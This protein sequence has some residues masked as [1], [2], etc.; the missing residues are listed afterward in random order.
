[1][2]EAKIYN[3]S[4][5]TKAESRNSETSKPVGNV[6]TKPHN[7]TAEHKDNGYDHITDW[8]LALF[9]FLLVI[10]TRRLYQATSGLFSETAGL[11]EAANQQRADMLRSIKAT[12]EL[13][14]T[15]RDALITTERPFVFLND[16]IPADF[17]LTPRG[18]GVEMLSLGL[19]PH[20]GNNGNTPT[21]DMKIQVNWKDCPN[22]ALPADFFYDYTDGPAPMFLGPKAFEWSE[23][24]KIS[25]P[26]ATNALYERSYIFVWGRAD[27]KDIFDATTP[28]FTKWC[29]RLVFHWDRGKPFLKPPDI[30]PV[31][32]GTYNGSDEDSRNT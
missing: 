27:Y 17:V 26:V 10:Y 30:Q 6:A 9:S 13:A 14:K 29:Y 23:A 16:L 24:I 15:A 4:Q 22:A 8:L 20:W 2:H 1:M 12:E 11:R 32:F 18:G 31:A 28:H 7:D 21:R 25:G 19:K 5:P 3:Q